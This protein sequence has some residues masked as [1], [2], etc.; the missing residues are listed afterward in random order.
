MSDAALTVYMIGEGRR[1]RGAGVLTHHNSLL[2]FW[3]WWASESGQDS[4]MARIPRPKRRSAQ[5]PVLTDR[6]VE[7]LLAA[8]RRSTAG[9]QDRALICFLISPGVRRAEACALTAADVDIRS[10]EA[11]IRG[12]RAATVGR[13]SSTTAQ[14]RPCNAT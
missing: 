7:D 4:P 6:Q 3:D 2:A 14:H 12:A 13:W 9:L 8:C 11:L 5:R 1:R 10:R